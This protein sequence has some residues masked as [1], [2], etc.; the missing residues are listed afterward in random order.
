MT[1]PTSGVH[2]GPP[3]RVVRQQTVTSDA[4]IN[5]VGLD[6][7]A[8][9]TDYFIRSGQSGA[10]S[11][12]AVPVN[13]STTGEAARSITRPAW[14]GPA[15]ALSA[16]RPTPSTTATD[17]PGA[18]H[19]DADSHL[20]TDGK[21]QMTN[22]NHTL[23]EPVSP[24]EMPDAAIAMLDAEGTVVGWTHAAEQL[25]GYSAGEVVGR[26]AAHVLPPAEDAPSASAFAE[27]C[28]AQEG[29]SGAVTVRHR[30]GHAIKMTLR[31][32]LLWGRDSRH[33]VAG[34]RDRHR[35]PVLGGVHGNCA[36]VAP[37]PRTDRH[38]RL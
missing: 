26:S 6:D 7:E 15:E 12:S 25:V 4:L 34:V 33:P 31:I 35:H 16:P 2:R 9:L 32:S 29:W 17:R 22:T 1:S 19:A 11:A 3:S 10:R 36:G 24:Q 14:P 27:Q 13:H 30:D 20:R 21:N 18:A 8:L 37:G 5:F 38:R 28:R 23:A